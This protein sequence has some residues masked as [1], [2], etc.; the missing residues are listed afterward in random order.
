MTSNLIAGAFARASVGLLVMPITIV[1]VRYESNLYNYTSITHA[2]QSIWASDGLRGLFYGYGSTIL[3]DAPYSGIYVLLYER[4]RSEF[5]QPHPLVNMGSAAFAGFIATGL[6]HPFDAVRTRIQL[7]P[8]RYPNAWA[9]FL[10]L[11]K[12][13]GV[14]SLFA[15]MSPRILRKTLSA[16]VTWTVYEELLHVFRK[17]RV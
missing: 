6:T 2:F 3:R 7:Q 10:R 13:D 8:D 1:K 9:T 17:N 15:G 16:A 14:R 4:L 5:T 12:E 11:V